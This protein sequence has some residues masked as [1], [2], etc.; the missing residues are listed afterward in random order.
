MGIEIEPIFADFL[1]Y[2]DYSDEID[3]NKLKEEIYDYIDKYEDGGIIKSNLGGFHS[4]DL[5]FEI[6]ENSEYFNFKKLLNNICSDVNNILE[7]NK[8]MISSMW[9]NINKSGDLNNIHA[10]QHSI[11]SGAFYIDIPDNLNNNEG[12][13]IFYRSR[14]YADYGMDNHTKNMHKIFKHSTYS[15]TPKPG[16]MVCFPGYLLHSVAP[17]FSE[18]NR[19]SVSFNMSLIK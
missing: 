19:I 4:K 11:I 10:H 18:K 3:L 2:N 15:I 14:E 1:A 6:I 12:Q 5:N 16:I 9:I 7:D 13:I 8:L 17:H